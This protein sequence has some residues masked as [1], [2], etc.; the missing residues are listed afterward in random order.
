MAGVTLNQ[1]A[2]RIATEQGDKVG[3]DGFI[4]QCEQWLREAM[5]EIDSQANSRA[6][7][8]TLPPITTSAGVSRYSLPENYRAIKYLRFVD[9]DD[10]IE[11]CNPRTLANYGVDFEQ[12]GRPRWHWVSDPVLGGSNE[13]IQKVTFQPIPNGTFTIDGM[14]F[15][16]IINIDSD[17]F[18]PLTQQAILAISSRLRMEIHKNDK[19]WDAYNAERGQFSINLASFLKLETNK[20]ARGLKAKIRDLP[21]MGRPPRLRYPFE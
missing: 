12:Q 7:S 21:R 4:T 13:F 16:D 8:T 17:D 20:P 9:T 10:P 3:D 5:I 18:L 15:F 1:I 6:F 19:E 11:Y 14:Y 2:V